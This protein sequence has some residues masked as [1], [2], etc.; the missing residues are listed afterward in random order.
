MISIIIQAGGKSTRMGFDKTLARLGGRPL[1]SGVIEHFRELSD[2][3]L[4]ISNDQGK[5]DF[6]GI[7]VYP[8]LIPGSGPLGGLQSG[9]MHARYPLAAVLACDMPFA[10]PALTAAQVAVMERT[11]C[12]VVLPVVGGKAEPLHGLY[13]ASSCLP[14]IQR[15]LAQG[16]TRLVDWHSEVEVYHMGTEEIR[17]YDPDL[18]A[19][20]NI[21]F[22]EDLQ[23]AEDILT[24]K[25]R[26]VL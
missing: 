22:P 4:I 16:R 2:D 12:D 21:N 11:G 20:F 25:S 3:L 8:D 24:R 17:K 14:A 7:P 10:S 13:R 26:Q 15:S 9:L 1:I 6:S 18:T 19:F 5:L 23:T